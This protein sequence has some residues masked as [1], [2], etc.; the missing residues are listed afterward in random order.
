MDERAFGLWGMQ[1]AEAV[2][3]ADLS[4][5]I[6]PADR[7]RVQAAFTATRS[8]PGPYEID[9]RI[10]VG[11]DIRWISARGQAAELDAPEAPMFGIFL[12]VTGRKQAEEGNELLAGEMSHRVK[13]LLAIATGLTQITSRSAESVEEMT[14]QLTR[15]LISLGRAHDLV[16]PLPGEQGKAALLGDL[17]A[18]LLS[19]YED[20]GAFSGRIR[21]AVPR[22]GVGEATATTLAMVVHELA[23]NSV[24]HGALSASTG[25]LDVSGRTEDGEVHVTWAETGGPEL[26]RE[27]EMAGFGSRMIQRSVASQLAG[28]LT[29]DWQSSGLVATLVMRQDR[30]GR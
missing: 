24:K 7:D 10:M 28:S 9:F 20:T 17:M 2:T 22:M 19:P 14:G 21:V 6:H 29:Y 26:K 4:T 30:M 5:H 18:V 23:T 16:R 15:R 12:D 1:W 13:N 3:F 27:P 8:V 25:S 11:D